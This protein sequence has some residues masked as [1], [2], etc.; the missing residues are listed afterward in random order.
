MGHLTRDN[1]EKSSLVDPG[2]HH[3]LDISDTKNSWGR[4]IRVQKQVSKT[5][6]SLIAGLQPYEN[7]IKN[8]SDG[9]IPHSWTKYS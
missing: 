5:V 1:S 9:K 2:I 4:I 6:E 7:P 3:E 8:M